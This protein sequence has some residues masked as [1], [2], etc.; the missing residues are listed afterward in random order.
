M[1]HAGLQVV[2]EGILG[3]RLPFPIWFVLAHGPYFM[4]KNVSSLITDKA[5]EPHMIVLLYYRRGQRYDEYQVLP[6]RESF[7]LRSAS[8]S[9]ACTIL[10][11]CQG[12][13]GSGLCMNREFSQ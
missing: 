6:D 5:N 11:A 1:K 7:R 12:E 2:E 3:I 9:M 13:R 8:R 4:Q 10:S